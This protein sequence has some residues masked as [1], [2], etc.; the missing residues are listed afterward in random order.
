MIIQDTWRSQVSWDE[1]V[2]DSIQT[3]WRKWIKLLEEVN[4]IRLPRPYFPGF[5]A[6]DIGCVDLHIFTDASEEAYAATAYFRTVKNEKV[7]CTLVMAKAKVA[8]LKAVSV[9]RLELMGALLGARLAKTV[10][11]YHTIPI[12]RRVLWTDSLATLAWIQSPH[13]RYRQF[14]AFRVGEILTKTEADEWRWVPTK[15][16]VADEATKWGKGPSTEVKSRWFQGPEFLYF[17]EEKWPI[18][19]STRPLVADEELRPSLVHH[20]MTTKDIIRWENFSKWERLLRAI[21][22][23]HRFVTNCRQQHNK[24]Q[25]VAGC[26]TKEELQK[27]E[28]SLWRVTQAIAYPDEIAV[29][30]QR[31]SN[32]KKEIEKTSPVYKLSPYL[33]EQGVMRMDSRIGTAPF[34]SYDF[35][36]PVILPRNH[37]STLLLINWYHRRYLHAN[38]ETVHNEIRQRFHVS[39]LRTVV[40]QVAKNCQVCKISKASPVTPKMAPL[41]DA[42]LAA[43]VRP[44]S[45]VGLDYFGPVQVKVGRSCVKRWIALFTCLTIRAVHLEIVHSLSTESCKMAVRRFVARRGSPVE[46]YSDNGTNFQGA[47]RE[48]RAEIE[49]TSKQLQETFTNT[50]TKW[51]FNPPSAPHFG[52]SWERLVRS[53]KVALGALCP[54]RNPTDETLITVIAEA[55]SVVN[56]R[57]LTFIPLEHSAQEALTPNHFILLSSSGVVQPPKTIAESTKV[58]RT[59]WTM[60]RILVDRFWKRWV[61]NGPNGSMNPMR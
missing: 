9:P 8:P 19:E 4:K 57:P 61:R 44:F 43:T 56:S 6:A 58:T 22:Y 50:N 39:N 45:Y 18:R 25:L 33:D 16:N 3:R 12:R 49:A 11:E 29:L 60:N 1:E 32:P 7:Y 23:V 51:L 15:H 38:N 55:E 13:C 37:P 47:S 28:L 10:C 20:V 53:V 59:N 26:L 42:R 48:L 41:P 31:L 14:V 24:Q 2:S 35:K 30:K 40:R 17:P 27:A 52:G 34:I 36:F 46:I 5:S 21:A 54:E